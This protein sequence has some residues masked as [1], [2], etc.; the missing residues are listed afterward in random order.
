MKPIGYYKTLIGYPNLWGKVLVYGRYRHRR[1]GFQVMIKSFGD[2]VW[3]NI[4][5]YCFVRANHL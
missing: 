3:I 4:S 1:L 5:V 2:M